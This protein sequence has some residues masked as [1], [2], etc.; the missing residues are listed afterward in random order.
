METHLGNMLVLIGAA[1]I[2]TFMI[3]RFY[4]NGVYT[5][6]GMIIGWIGLWIPTL[7]MLYYLSPKF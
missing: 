5:R 3:Y 2:L 1:I 6:A 7:F 4:R